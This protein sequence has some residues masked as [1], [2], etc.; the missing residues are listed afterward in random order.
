VEKGFGA[1]VV[2]S[3]L[4][5]KNAITTFAGETIDFINSLDPYKTPATPP[6]KK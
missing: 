1:F 4:K 2:F 5:V 6:K 3:R